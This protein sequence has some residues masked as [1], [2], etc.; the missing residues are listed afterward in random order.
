MSFHCN[1]SCTMKFMMLPYSLINRCVKCRY[2]LS[3]EGT[4]WNLSTRL[5]PV[6]NGQIVLALHPLASRDRTDQMSDLVPIEHLVLGIWRAYDSAI[7]VAYFLEKIRTLGR[8]LV[9]WDVDEPKRKRFFVRHRLKPKMINRSRYLLR[10]EGQGCQSRN[11]RKPPTARKLGR[12]KRDVPELKL[13]RLAAVADMLAA[14]RDQEHG[15]VS[16]GDGRPFCQALQRCPLPLPP[17]PQRA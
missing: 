4:R 1:L 11:S 5:M 3:S 7:L 13:V 12:W 10:T 14:R 15:S 9:A 2:R 16:N 8:P 17:P 6:S